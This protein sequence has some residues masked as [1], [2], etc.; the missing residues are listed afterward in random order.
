[1]LWFE[2]WCTES[3][4]QELLWFTSKFKKILNFVG[5]LFTVFKYV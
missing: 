3:P 1:M 4:A 2:T 5:Y